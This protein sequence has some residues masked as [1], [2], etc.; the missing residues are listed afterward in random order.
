MKANGLIADLL[1][2]FNGSNVEITFPELADYNLKIQVS[3]TLKKKLSFSNC[4]LRKCGTYQ[5]LPVVFK[6]V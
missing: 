1:N 3:N 4:I 5:A 2:Y 6:T